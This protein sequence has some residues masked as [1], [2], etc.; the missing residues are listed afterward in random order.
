MNRIQLAVCGATSRL[1]EAWMSKL[2]QVGVHQNRV[3]GSTSGY[4]PA[5]D[6]Y[7]VAY[8]I[9]DRLAAHSMGAATT[10]RDRILNTAGETSENVVERQHMNGS[11]THKGPAITRGCS[12]PWNVRVSGRCV[13]FNSESGWP[14][15]APT[16]TVKNC[17]NV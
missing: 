9:P 14:G 16:R 5:Y 10:D 3:S 17:Q 15:H 6:T 7:L 8:R 2:S 1:S 12:T 13:R 4:G 11:I